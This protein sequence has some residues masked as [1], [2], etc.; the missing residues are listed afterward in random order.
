MMVEQDVYD[1]L[2]RVGV[3][4]PDRGRYLAHDAEGRPIGNF[5]SLQAARAAVMAAR[6]GNYRRG[7][8]NGQEERA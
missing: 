5:S 2:A 4:T 7:A 8:V 3:I 1:G 6:R